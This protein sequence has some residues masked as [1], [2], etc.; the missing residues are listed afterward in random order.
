M[1][2]FTNDWFG[3]TGRYIWEKIIPQVRP[4][5]ILEVGSY[6]GRSACFLLDTLSPIVEGM[7]VHCI[8]TW[9]GGDEHD[10]TQMAAVEKR[11]D[12]NTK[13]AL[14]GNEGNTLRFY[15][16]KGRSDFELAKL[17]KHHQNFFDFIYIDGSHQA[18]DVLCDAVLAFRMLKPSGIMCFDDYLWKESTF[19]D[20]V[21]A[22]K[23]AIDA[24]TA[25]YCRQLNILPLP[26]T[27]L[28][29]EKIT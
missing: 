22:P 20:P 5:K 26:P 3:A 29:I 28:F 8:D 16:H 14:R 15:K 17:L 21:R 1:Y 24:F 12:A 9:E 27:Q 18:A 7:T 13:L 23:M 25:M 6:E 4:T 10:K 19:A 2:E 11:F